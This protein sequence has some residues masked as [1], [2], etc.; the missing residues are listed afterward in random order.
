MPRKIS[1]LIAIATVGALFA[2]TNASANWREGWGPGLVVGFYGFPSSFVGF[3]YAYGGPTY[4]GC[5]YQWERTGFS[6]PRWK[7]ELHCVVPEIVF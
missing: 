7:R 6:I 3:P 2:A 1:I 5:Y 4:G